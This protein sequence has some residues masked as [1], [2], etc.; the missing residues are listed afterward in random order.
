MGKIPLYW[1]RDYLQL[2][3]REYRLHREISAADPSVNRQLDP[4]R[5]LSGCQHRT[6]E[7]QMDL[8]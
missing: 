4:R 7:E 2:L 5:I 8:D 3:R 1:E 6:A